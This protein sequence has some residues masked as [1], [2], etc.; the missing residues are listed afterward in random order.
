MIKQFFESLGFRLITTVITILAIVVVAYSLFS[1]NR[2]RG[3]AYQELQTKGDLM[4]RHLAFSA[5]L[6]VFT[7]NANLLKNE[8]AGL[9]AEQD[10]VQVGIYNADLKTLY[11]RDK[12]TSKTVPEQQDATMQVLAAPPGKEVQQAK[13]LS[14]M[15]FVMPVLMKQYVQSGKAMYLEGQARELPERTIG[16]VR[17]VLSRGSLN[18]ELRS[19]LLTNALL[20]FLFIAGSSAIAYVWM[21]KAVKPLESLTTQVRAFGEGGHV[22]EV[23]VQTRDE[24]GRLAQAFNLMLEERKKAEHALEKI[25]MDIHD[26]IGGITTNIALLSEVARQ[27]SSPE[28]STRALQTIG[29]LARD[30]MAEVRSLMYSLDRNDLS[31]HTLA[32][33]L[34]NHAIKYIG[35]R[36]TEFKMTTEVS[37]DAAVPSSYLCLN[38]FKIYREVLT[39]VIKHADA[40]K[41]SVRLS[42][43]NARL[44]LAVQDD[45][46]GCPPVAF[47]GRGR[48][49]NNIMSRARE[50]NGTCTIRGEAGTCVIVEVPLGTKSPAA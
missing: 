30:G 35:S 19:I 32:A 41:V 47:N 39:N 22:E 26:G 18:R 33:E 24:I 6:A 2:A 34:R 21:K 16:Y 23:K 48:G 31:W 27:A 36:N 12:L 45:G 14:T 46:R 1:Y 5:R 7:E 20:A 8:A 25:L 4:A 3:R 37:V 11:L 15:A 43:D 40:T 29:D 28:D 49:I 38:L 13:D 10:V 44:V 9:E 50:M 17:V 42:V